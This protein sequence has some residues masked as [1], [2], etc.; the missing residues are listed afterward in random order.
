MKIACEIIRDLLPLYHDGV[1]SME[2]RE[3]VEEHLTE[4]GSCSGELLAMDTVLPVSNE[5]SQWDDAKS[6]IQL[7]KKWKKGMLRSVLKGMLSTAIAFAVLIIIL[8]LFIDIK[9]VVRP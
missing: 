9:I 1:C 8:Y 5:E 4:C 3:L 2:S 6:V 7:S